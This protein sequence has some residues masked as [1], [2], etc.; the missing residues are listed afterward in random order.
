MLSLET[1]QA[2]IKE[3]QTKEGDTGS[4]EVQIAILTKEIEQ[5]NAHLSYH[6]HDFA[7]KRGLHSKI[8]QR[9]SLL[10]Y[11]EKKDSKRYI[12]LKQKLNLR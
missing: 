12:A 1:K 11:L 2:I 9:R 6:I 10:K 8:G 3:F 7:S 5:L 4:A